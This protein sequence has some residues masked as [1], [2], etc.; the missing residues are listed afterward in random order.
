MWVLIATYIT[1][2]VSAVVAGAEIVS[3]LRTFILEHDRGTRVV[4]LFKDPQIY[5]LLRRVGG[6]NV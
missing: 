3:W 4:A 5:G 6:F 2:F 1:A